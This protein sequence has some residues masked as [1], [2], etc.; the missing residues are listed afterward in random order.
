MLANPEW[1]K[2]AKDEANTPSHGDVPDQFAIL[3]VRYARLVTGNSFM[4][5]TGTCNASNKSLVSSPLIYT[6][7][8]NGN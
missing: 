4:S 8:H 2:V 1:M 6:Y 3:A 5:F 7:Y